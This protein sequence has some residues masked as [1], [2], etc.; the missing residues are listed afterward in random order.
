M[1]EGMVK[2]VERFAEVLDL[3]SEDVLEIFMSM[4]A[5]CYDGNQEKFLDDLDRGVVLTAD[6]LVSARAGLS[7]A[8]MSAYENG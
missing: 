1:A 7:D 8:L 5:T 6:G 4:V 2:Y 3:N